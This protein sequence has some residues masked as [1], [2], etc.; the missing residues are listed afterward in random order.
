MAARLPK[1]K[2]DQM[3][4]FSSM[5]KL[6]AYARKVAFSAANR[7]RKQLSRPEVSRVSDPT[8][9]ADESIED[10]LSPYLEFLPDKRMREVTR[11]LFLENRT[12]REIARLLDI[13][14]VQVGVIK[15]S[16]LEILM[17]R[18]EE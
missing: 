9:I 8:N 5:A 1:H 7:R 3:R 15:K 11:M 4:E 12:Y 18:L 6:C 14:S 17:Q 10:W 13:P 16:V 2:T